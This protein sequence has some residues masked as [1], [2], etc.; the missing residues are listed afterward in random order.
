MATNSYTIFIVEDDKGL[1]SLIKMNLKDAGFK[2]KVAFS[3][4]EALTQ[5]EEKSDLLML[6]DYS[7]PDMNAKEMVSA[8]MSRSQ[9]IP[10]I[11]MT[12]NGS[13]Q[14]AIEMMKLGARDYL[15][16]ESGF[17][18]LVPEVIKSVVNQLTTENS[19]VTTKR[20]LVDSENRFHAM[21][22]NSFQFTWLLNE[23]GLVL[24]A[25][26]KVHQFYGGSQNNIIGT[27]F[28]SRPGFAEI[29]KMLEEKT[30][31]AAGNNP[32]IFEAETRGENNEVAIIEFSIKPLLDEEG[33][34][35]QII[36]EG[37]DIT[38]RKKAE[39][40]IRELN[41]ELERRVKVRTLELELANKS[42]RESF[43]EL[44]TAK[45]QLVQSE[46]MASLGSLVSGVAHEINTPIGI[47][48]T[49]AS[50]LEDTTI[51][52]SQLYSSGSMKRSDLEAYVKTATDAS[53]T[54]LSNM[55]RAAE[56]IRIFKQVA[57][58]QSSETKRRFMLKEYIDEVLFSL[59]PKYKNTNHS[60]TV[61]CP[62]TLEIDSFPGVFFQIITNFV[63]NSLVHAFDK[64]EE[65]KI[66]FDVS[67][68]GEKLI[69]QYSDNGSG[70]DA[71][72]ERKIFDPFFTTKR[73]HGGTGLG[74]HIVFNLV[75]RTLN[76]EISC[77]SAP[78][79]GITF[80]ITIPLNKQ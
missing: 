24:E 25:N 60:V 59:Q 27:P 21:F 39:K 80:T 78:G 74:L 38:V 71:E 63:T 10:F 11:I 22:N 46:K 55:N 56:L 49:A 8:I 79:K 2:T 52:I 42:L 34:V 51:K 17:I 1:S 54:I 44:N 75:T 40:E 67:T 4:D 58:D 15:I 29:T 7:L 19:L 76:G 69:F 68:K 31:E 50:F 35:R 47:G 65:G 77:S 72:T 18:D 12:G 6:L 3:G 13:E 28:W 14:I 36:V 37:H 5:L 70:V 43:D 53:V 57:V 41:E 20:A 61:N 33:V 62:E 64:T 26:K 23:E 48:I 16:K 45:D 73:S 9:H 66:I 30:R 32:L